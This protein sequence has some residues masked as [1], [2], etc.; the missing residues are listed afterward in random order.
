MTTKQGPQENGGSNTATSNSAERARATLPRHS[1]RPVR[2][3]PR[4]PQPGDSQRTGDSVGWGP[5][6]VEDPGLASRHCPEPR[7]QMPPRRSQ[8]PR[9]RIVPRILYPPGA[10]AK[11]AFR[12]S[13]LGSFKLRKAGLC[14]DHGQIALLQCLKTPQNGLQA[15]PSFHTFEP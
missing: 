2:S 1:P 15:I 7:S 11:G 12:T 14:S 3:W 8:R 9:D 13:L 5:P 10:K 6:N 4:S